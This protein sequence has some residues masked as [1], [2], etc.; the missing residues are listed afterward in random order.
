MSALETLSAP[1]K[2]AC[3]LELPNR[4][5]KVDHGELWILYPYT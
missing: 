1:L 2:L 3:G 5:A 4:L